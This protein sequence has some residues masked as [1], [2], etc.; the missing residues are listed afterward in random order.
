[1]TCIDVT[2]SHLVLTVV[3]TDNQIHIS[4]HNPS[5]SYDLCIY[6]SASENRTRIK[7]LSDLS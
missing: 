4:H 3:L 5:E 1:M 7:G 6:M 2:S